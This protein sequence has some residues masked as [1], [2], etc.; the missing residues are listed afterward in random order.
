[1]AHVESLAVYPIKS[2]AGNWLQ[3]ARVE[4]RGLLGDRQ[5]ML[6]DE[7]QRFITGRLLPQ[8]VGVIA[9]PSTDGLRIS[10]PGMS[11][12]DVSAPTDAPRQTVS[13]WSDS[14]SAM[15]AGDAAATWFSTLCAK[16]VRLMYADERMHRPVNANYAVGAHDE[17]AF[18]D[19]FP[20]LLLS[21]TAVTVLSEKV[22][23]A[24]DVRR[25][26][27]NIVIADSAAHAEDQWRRI[28]IG[29]VE[30]AVVKPCVRCVFTTVDP[31]LATRDADGE[32]LATLKTYRNID[33]GV[34][35][36]MNAIALNVGDVRVGDRI[37]VLS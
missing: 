22:G 25:F 37:E 29:E 14:V 28:R 9:T 4:R 13:I 30:L 5:W 18:P 24:M 26:R 27:P 16:S 17:V 12:L 32:P 21:R 1:M 35:F 10:A 36:G 33:K 15:D 2:C 7:K 19:G 23:R 20:I 8:L 34:I 11:S 31:D 6:V 3:V